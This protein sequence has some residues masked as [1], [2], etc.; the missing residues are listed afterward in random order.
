[1]EYKK[2]EK[3]PTQFNNSF[4]NKMYSFPLETRSA[5]MEEKRKE[6][7]DYYGGGMSNSSFDTYELGEEKRIVEGI[8]E[9]NRFI[10]SHENVQKP[11]QSLD[12]IKARYMEE[13]NALTKRFQDEIN[14][15]G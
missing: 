3:T 2:E 14:N 5:L 8:K 10:N 13:M 11:K 12:E 9:R 7:E 4:H 15:L 1:M 6:E